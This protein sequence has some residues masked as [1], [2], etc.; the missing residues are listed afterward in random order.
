MEESA[1]IGPNAIIQTVAALKETCGTAR[2]EEIL[3]AGGLPHLVDHMPDHMVREQEFFSLIHLLLDQV[4]AEEAMRILER[5][6]HLTGDYVLRHRIP[7]PFQRLLMW[8]AVPRQMS[9]RLLML[10][11]ARSAWTFVGSGQFRFEGGNKCTISITN[12]TPDQ[13]IPAAICS[14]YGGTFAKLVQ[15]LIDARLMVECITE[16]KD[17]TIRCAYRIIRE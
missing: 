17:D 8:R 15:V 5:S 9:L 10:A 13:A 3:H 14:F 2:A 16:G 7:H 11:I 4:G 1:R 6:G 12:R